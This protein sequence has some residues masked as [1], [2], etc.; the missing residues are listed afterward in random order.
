MEQAHGQAALSGVFALFG[1]P[2]QQA[3][4]TRDRF[5]VLAGF[6]QTIIERPPVI[7]QGDRAPLVRRTLNR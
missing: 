2:A 1:D 4:P 7:H 6:D 5:V 3:R